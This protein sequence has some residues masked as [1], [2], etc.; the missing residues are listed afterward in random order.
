MHTIRLRDPWQCEQRIN[1]C[2]FRRRFQKPTNLSLTERVMLQITSG[3]MA[4]DVRL[5]DG[6]LGAFVPDVPTVWDIREQLQPSNVLEI[7]I[8]GVWELTPEQQRVPG[9]LLQEVHLAIFESA[10]MPPL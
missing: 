3:A 1:G 10:E 6:V 5:N 4:G 8:T 7:Q 2:V 9:S